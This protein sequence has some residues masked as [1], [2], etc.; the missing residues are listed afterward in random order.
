MSN[1]NNTNETL[2][3]KRKNHVTGLRP[4]DIFSQSSDFDLPYS[5]EQKTPNSK[6]TR[7]QIGFN[8]DE[9][10]IRQIEN[11]K[12][13]ELSKKAEKQAEKPNNPLNEETIPVHLRAEFQPTEPK[14]KNVPVSELYNKQRQNSKRLA[15][16]KSDSLMS[17]ILNFYL[18]ELSITKTLIVAAAASALAFG[19]Y[20]TKSLFNHYFSTPVTQ[21]FNMDRTIKAPDYAI[22]KVKELTPNE[23]NEILLYMDYRAADVVNQASEH[24]HVLSYAVK[25]GKIAQKDAAALLNET[26]NIHESFIS[27]IQRDKDIMTIFYKQSRDPSQEDKLF[28]V[29]N[30]QAETLSRV[31]ALGKDGEDNPILKDTANYKTNF[32][33]FK[34]W[35]SRRDNE[36]Y[37]F[38]ENI[39]NIKK[40]IEKTLGV[41]YY[42]ETL[43][44]AHMEIASGIKPEF[45]SILFDSV[46][47]PHEVKKPVVDL[48]KIKGLNFTQAYKNQM[49]SSEAKKELIAESPQIDLPKSNETIPEIKPSRPKP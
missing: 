31:L 28:R 27:D 42:K 38:P 46:A 7:P 10:I 30:P 37:Y 5:Q 1:K 24:W 8:V 21:E 35:N 15:N 34:E 32:E 41:Q 29:S 20:E 13:N 36:R 47:N 26:K 25:E 44:F 22:K 45:N 39:S 11:K 40:K 49:F 3:G 12:I 6:K 14:D 48:S 4:E 43:F 23:M 16:P 9:F 18:S 17:N 19:Y 2:F 33:R